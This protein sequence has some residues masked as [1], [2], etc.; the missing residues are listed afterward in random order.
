MRADTQW[1]PCCE[2]RLAAA[3]QPVEVAVQ[4]DVL[5][6]PQ[7]SQ[8][9]G[10]ERLALGLAKQLAEELGLGDGFR[11]DSDWDRAYWYYLQSVMGEYPERHTLSLD[12]RRPSLAA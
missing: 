4:R 12:N 5:F 7:P 11:D 2:D 8:V 1:Q 10:L 3:P 6:E 9:L